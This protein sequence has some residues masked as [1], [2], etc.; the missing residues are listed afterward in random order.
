M[1]RLTLTVRVAEAS[2]RETGDRA[3]RVGDCE[4]HVALLCPRPGKDEV[5]GT[6]GRVPL[7]DHVH[8]A[9]APDRPALFRVPVLKEEVEGDVAMLVQVVEGDR[10]GKLARVLRRIGQAAIEAGGAAALLAAPGSIRRAFS[11][12]IQD[13]AVRL[14]DQ[15]DETLD[16]VAV[17]DEPLVLSADRLAEMARSGEASIVSLAL[18]AP[19]DLRRPGE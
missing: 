13:G 10:A 1:S 8:D 17:C 9:D 12:A 14:G 16:V 2:L 18:S 3:D 19:R 7:T 11:D 4:V 6:T 15:P 5:L